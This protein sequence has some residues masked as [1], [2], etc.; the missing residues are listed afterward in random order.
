MEKKL[1][2][3][4]TLIVKASTPKEKAKWEKKRIEYR[5]KLSSFKKESE[6]ASPTSVASKIEVSPVAKELLLPPSLDDDGDENETKTKKIKGRISIVPSLTLQAKLAKENIESGSPKQE[7]SIATPPRGNSSNKSKAS[8]RKSKSFAVNEGSDVPS[9]F[10]STQKTFSPKKSTRKLLRNKSVGQLPTQEKV[11]PSPHRNKSFSKRDAQPA[12]EVTSLFAPKSTQPSETSVQTM[13]T[14]QANSTH[15][16]YRNSSVAQIPT[17]EKVT[18][19]PRKNKS[20]RASKDAQSASIVPS[21]FDPKSSKPTSKPSKPLP[22]KTKSPRKTELSPPAVELS[23][24]SSSTNRPVFLASGTSLGAFIDRTATAGKQ[25]EIDETQSMSSRSMTSRSVSDRSHA[26]RS[27]SE[28]R[29]LAKKKKKKKTTTNSNKKAAKI[30]KSKT[31]NH[32]VQKTKVRTHLGQFMPRIKAA[33]LVVNNKK[34]TLQTSLKPKN[35][36]KVPRVGGAKTLRF[37]EGHEEFEIP[38][39][40]ASLYDDLFWTEEELAD[41]RHEAFLQECGLDHE[42]YL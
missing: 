14:T 17:H 7:L 12:G 41:F 26:E 16:P 10:A 25:N 35:I 11:K 13:P 18:P 19:P 33:T 39:L 15:K 21:L 36:T 27:K 4:E 22:V 28:E 29:L 9:L 30:S 32:L 42:L 6:Q 24:G 1:A 34:P 20:F 37:K 40:E 23:C 8:P 31:R 5:E 38:A 3:C 2:K